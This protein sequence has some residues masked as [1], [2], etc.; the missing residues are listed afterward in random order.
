MKDIKTRD[1]AKNIKVLDKSAVAAEHMK[2]AAI[3]S[4]E[5]AMTMQADA[6]SSTDYGS[7]QIES[8]ASNAAHD[9]AHVG[10]A[11]PHKAAEK[12]RS[13]KAK[14]SRDESE[15]V[16]END[17][18]NTSQ[19]AEAKSKSQKENTASASKKDNRKSG[20]V[21]SKDTSSRSS[22]SKKQ[23]VPASNR[24]I[25][26]R[27]RNTSSVKTRKASASPLKP[28][29]A[30]AKSISRDVKTAQTTAQVS[31]KSAAV[32]KSARTY[33]RSKQAASAGAKAAA[34]GAKK[35]AVA[36]KKYVKAIYEAAK[37][38]IAAISA[39][40]S[41][42][43]L[44]VILICTLG[45]I[46]G[47]SFGILFSGEDTGSGQTIRDAIREI[48]TEYETNLETIRNTNPHDVVE[49][50]GSRA[51]WKDVLS[52]YAVRTTTDPDNP[53]EVVS[54]TDDK[55]ELLRNIFWEMNTITSAVATETRTITTESDDGNGNIVVETEEA[56]QQVLH[57]TVTHKT[58]EEM[59][60]SYSFNADQNTQLTEL[61][62]PDYASLWNAALYGITAS[63]TAIVDVALSQIGNVG[64]Q[65]Y[66][67]WYGFGSRVSWC[68]C[69]VSWC[70]N[71]CGYIDNGIIPRYSYCPTGEEWFK[72]R[73]QWAERDITPEPGMI[74]FFDWDKDGGQDGE[75]DHTGV[76]E[77]VEDGRVYTIEGNSGDSCRERSYPIGWYEIYGYGVVLY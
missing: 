25:K 65:P 44:V 38:L 54:M 57:I 60:S 45:L 5:Q 37:S 49:M 58:V 39:G 62:S 29:A 53:Q 19:H 4:K 63:D 36:A 30:K 72:A 21:G 69:F 43:A 59:A 18:A 47:S 33:A 76:V 12:I 1:H 2:Q 46:L 15:P 17:T 48:N 10:T 26:Q 71:E 66:W 51:V 61:M 67:S 64:G 22:G 68:A 9:A 77:K 8:T 28:Q 50:T 73:G 32:A 11:I 16:P 55:K 56:E 7:Q 31:A 3:R 75:T 42:A 13:E 6:E 24:D 35:A 74:I 20:G 34:R 70:A 14:R 27:V 41:V 40:G 52:V 23:G